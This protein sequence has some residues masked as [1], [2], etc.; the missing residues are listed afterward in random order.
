MLHVVAN[1]LFSCATEALIARV[2]SSLLQGLVNIFGGRVQFS[3]IQSLSVM[4]QDT[5]VKVCR[6]LKTASTNA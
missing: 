1:I 4:L 6:D 3:S 5:Y 2:G